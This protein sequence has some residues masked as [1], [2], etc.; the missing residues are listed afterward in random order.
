MNDKQ[1]CWHAS[2]ASYALAALDSGLQGLAASEARHR[3]TVHG[4]NLLAEPNP[5]GVISRLARQFNNLLLIVL[6]VASA[7]TAAMGHWIDS[8]V[9]AL[10]VLLNA[11]IGFVQEGKAERALQAIRHLLAPHAVV[12]RDG[13]EYDIDAADL[14]PGDIVLL[15]SGDSLPADVRLL[16]A[17]NLRVDE[18]AL[19]GESVP[20]DKD[21]EPVSASAVIGDRLCMGYSGTLVTQGQARAIVVATGSATEMGRIGRMLVSVEAGTTPLLEKMSVFGRHLT[22]VILGIAAGL[23][24]FGTL[25]RG[26]TIADTFMA[27]VSL[28]VAAIPEG[29]PAI[30]TITLAIGVQRMARRHA[31]IRRLP[32]VETLGSVTV[33]CSDKTGTLTRNEMTVQSVICAGQHFDV[34]GAGYAPAGA[35][36]CD[37]QAVDPAL[38]RADSALVR[39]AEAA[40]LCNDA[41]LRQDS[42]GWQL[43]G[44][45]TE[46][47]LLNLAMKAGLN[48][49][50]LKMERERLDV[51]PFE[52]EHRFMAS[53]H[54]HG[55]GA[56]VLVKR[57][58]AANAVYLR[59]ADAAVVSHGSPGV[60]L[61]LRDPGLRRRGA[62][63]P[64]TGEGHVASFQPAGLRRQAFG[65]QIH[66][67]NLLR[68]FAPAAD[69]RFGGCGV[70]AA[71]RCDMGRDHGG[72][73]C[74]GRTVFH[75]GGDL[76]VGIAD[77]SS[78]RPAISIE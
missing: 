62:Y 26:M 21:A 66:A 47:A 37:G 60:G 42:Y 6:M 71:G 12:L 50:E 24:A 39:L 8:G 45:P 2:E 51:I 48:P 57:G 33:I 64:R 49:T 56:V 19:T 36:L 32:A 74:R 1:P 3:L 75:Q 43:A 67:R 44:D 59:S 22:L 58:F 29:L 55:E 5:P 34:E 52:S 25:V 15:A 65:N 28:A 73:D 23:F 4:A 14:V 70:R 7:V 9:I 18:S 61:G 11:L 54:K 78:F 17:R 76:C 40:A 41:S 46:G 53:L 77:L 27:A 35:I 10:V 13:R 69:L 16:Q 72:S 38:S 30:L 63:G 68:V 31:V 20:V